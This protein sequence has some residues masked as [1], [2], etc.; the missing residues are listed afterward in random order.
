MKAKGGKSGAEQLND[1]LKDK[2]KTPT[3]PNAP[4][5]KAE[6]VLTDPVAQN[7]DN[8]VEEFMN[9]QGRQVLNEVNPASALTDAKIQKDLSARAVRVAL[10]VIEQD[11]TFRL[12][13]N[14]KTSTAIAEVFS[15]LDNI[16]DA[17]LEQA[18]RKEGLTPDEFAAANKLTVT[19]AAQVMQQYSAASKVL[20]RMSEIDPEFKK[21]VDALFEKPDEYVSALGR[22]G[23][24][25]QTLER[26]SKAWIVSGIGTTVRNVIG[27]SIGLT[28]N[29]AAS[30][31]EGALYTVGRTLD[32]AASGKRIET[33]KNTVIYRVQIASSTAKKGS[34]NIAI[35]G[36]GGNTHVGWDEERREEYRKLQSIIKS[37]EN[38]KIDFFS[39]L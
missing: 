23:Q 18:I 29:S 7:M 16:D 13:P 5:T 33:A 8:V 12:R 28:Y 36:D 26:E 24:G 15:Q 10:H 19:E 1:I 6:R 14:Q 31:I 11:P 9:I 25:I 22:L 32:G 37:G 3:D 17:L 4:P 34:Y 20:K 35:G 21:Q 39:F 2:I 27:T 30:L 38:L